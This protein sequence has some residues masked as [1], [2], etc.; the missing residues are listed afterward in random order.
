[1]TYR[2]PIPLSASIVGCDSIA[3]GEVACELFPLNMSRMLLLF[4]LDESLISKKRLKW[5]QLI[6]KSET[7]ETIEALKQCLIVIAITSRKW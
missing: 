4:L 3:E 7:I 1:L 5:N 6:Y 2:Y